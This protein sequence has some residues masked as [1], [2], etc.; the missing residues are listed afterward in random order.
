MKDKEEQMQQVKQ[1][2]DREKLLSEK[3]YESDY[4]RKL[5]EKQL[6][7]TYPDMTQTD[8]SQRQSIT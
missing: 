1:A 8:V 3:V 7:V 4:L 6:D 5:L 2:L